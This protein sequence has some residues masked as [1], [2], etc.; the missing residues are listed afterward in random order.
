MWKDE[1]SHREN[2]SPLRSYSMMKRKQWIRTNITLTEKL[3]RILRELVEE[4]D[5]QSL[6]DFIKEAIREHLRTWYP[7]KL[8][9]KD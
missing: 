8:E 1:A 2:V 4:G 7:K 9:G 3:L 5:Y 6:S